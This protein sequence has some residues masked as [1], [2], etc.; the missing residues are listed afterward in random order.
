VHI[1]PYQ[2]L[3]FTDKEIKSNQFYVELQLSNESDYQCCV[4]FL[5]KHCLI[6]FPKVDK[7][8]QFIERIGQGSQAT[9]DLY[10]SK[11]FQGPTTV[12]NTNID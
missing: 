1:R 9:V 3:Q 4:L 2:S 8:F 7:D 6:S 5:T 10:K 12:G 11:I